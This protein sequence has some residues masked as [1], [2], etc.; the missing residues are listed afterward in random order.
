MLC[1]D[2]VVKQMLQELYWQEIDTARLNFE[3]DPAY[4][5]Y[6]T[7]SQAIWEGADMPEPLFHLLETSNYLS[8]AHGFRLGLHL[9][10]WAEE[11]HGP[12]GG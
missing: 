4:Q 9:G 10:R 8:F 1:G 5:T 6:F 11:G 7:E 3:A 2:V 12:T